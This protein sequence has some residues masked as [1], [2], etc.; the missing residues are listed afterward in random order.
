MRIVPY[1]GEES[2]EDLNTLGIIIKAVPFEDGFVPA[3]SMIAPDDNYF[4]TIDEVNALMDGIEIAGEKLDDLIAA[5]LQSKIAERLIG[6]EDTIIVYNQE[7]EVDE[8][9]NG[10]D[11]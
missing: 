6:L 3:Y 9:D 5:M 1:D 4:I 11:N 8:D 7:E 2:I 10:E